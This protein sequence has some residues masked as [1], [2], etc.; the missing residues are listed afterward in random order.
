MIA[1]LFPQHRR[2][3]SCSVTDLISGN[4]SLHSGTGSKKGS[5]PA[6]KEGKRPVSRSPPRSPGKDK[7]TAN[8]KA[9]KGTCGLDAQIV[10]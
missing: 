8:K 6:S 4:D 9:G 7:D 3:V 1:V 10:L 5:R 2:F